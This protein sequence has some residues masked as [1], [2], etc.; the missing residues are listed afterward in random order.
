MPRQPREP[1]IV[2]P[3]APLECEVVDRQHGLKRQSP[4]AIDHGH[5]RRLPVVHVEDLRRGQNAA[6]QLR[7]G[8]REKDEA[9]RVVVVIAAVL[10]IDPG[11]VEVL[12]VA[13]QKDLHAVGIR[14]LHYLR[15]HLPAAHADGNLH[16]RALAPNALFLRQPAIARQHHTHLMPALRQRRRQRLDH[17]R[18]PTRAGQRVHLTSGEKNRH[19]G[20]LPPP[21][22]G[23]PAVFPGGGGRR[24]SDSVP[25]INPIPPIIW[26]TTTVHHCNH[27]E[28][29]GL[30]GVKYS[31]G[32][33]PNETPSHVLNKNRPA[34]R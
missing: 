3:E 1:E 15:L 28:V 5:Q 21:R 23:H 17:I 8:T 7:H 34:C 19:A 11:P 20:K 16:A 10:A 13:N 9:L 4:F 33:A 18:Q 27:Q 14:S 25:V 2:R 12:I 31:V 30:Y 26:L 29:V 24:R 32:K 22:A 6:R